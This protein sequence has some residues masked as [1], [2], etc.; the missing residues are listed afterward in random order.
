MWPWGH[1][2]VGYLLYTMYT[3]AQFD[4]SP[5]GLPVLVLAFGTQFPDLID[6]PMAWTLSLLP[7]GR[8]LVHSLL[9]AAAVLALVS[10]LAKKYDSGRLVVP[11]G[12]GYLS[13]LAADGV[14]AVSIG[15]YADLSYLFWPVLAV[16]P[17]ESPSFLAHFMNMELTAFS[18]LQLVLVLVALVV[19]I[20]DGTPG[21][22]LR[23]IIPD[24]H[25]RA[26]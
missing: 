19:W 4:R 23:A 12:L 17:D 7:S 14:Y 18:I 8:S 15:A 3:H 2:A 22:D 24:S 10:V 9:V 5:R 11:F 20:W 25:R 6:K 26:E 16:G 1:L 21:S 13:H